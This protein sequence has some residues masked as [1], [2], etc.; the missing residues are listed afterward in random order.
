MV[1]SNYY[2]GVQRHGFIDKETDQE[3]ERINNEAYDEHIV[4]GEEQVVFGDQEAEADDEEAHVVEK[5]QWTQ[6][7]DEILIENYNQFASLEKKS[8]FTFLAELV[9]GAKTY[10]DCYKRAKLLKLKNGTVAESKEISN[11]LLNKQ[12]EHQSIKDRLVRHALSTLVKHLKEKNDGQTDFAQVKA[13]CS[14]LC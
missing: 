11:S 5:D 12:G 7:Q 8:R 9:G 2:I 4:F 14:Y 6:K 1:L 3:K 13:M 10:K